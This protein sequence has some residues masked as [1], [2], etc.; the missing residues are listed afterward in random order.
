MM[1]SSSLSVPFDH[2]L[3]FP[4]PRNGYHHAPADDDSVASMSGFQLTTCSPFPASPRLQ[5]RRSLISVHHRTQLFDIPLFTVMACLKL[6]V[7]QLRMP[8]ALHIQYLVFLLKAEFLYDKSRQFLS[9]RQLLTLLP[10]H[11]KTTDI[12]A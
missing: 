6:S 2:D 5:I 10:N 7:H 8:M 4:T 1:Q 9:H 11:T 3:G 12:Q